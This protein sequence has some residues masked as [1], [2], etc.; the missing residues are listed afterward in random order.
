MTEAKIQ[1]TEENPGN[2]ENHDDNT[3]NEKDNSEEHSELSLEKSKKDSLG[4]SDDQEN[5]DD[6]GSLDDSQSH[7]SSIGG[8]TFLTSTN[9]ALVSN[10][11]PAPKQEP[12]QSFPFSLKDENTKK[13]LINLGYKEKDLYYPTDLEL[14]LYT[15]DPEIKET[16]KKKL[17]GIV[18]QRIKA[19]SEERLR[20][21]QTPRN[22]PRTNSGGDDDYF[23]KKNKEMEDN[24]RKEIERILIDFFKEK[25]KREQELKKSEN[26]EKQKAKV[27]EETRQRLEKKIK[28][29]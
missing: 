23:Q 10:Q 8:Q 21:V 2:E 20:L 14:N 26:S 28:R 18:D 13:A 11:T 29:G 22:H 17:H 25:I 9:N 15:H 24:Q 4:N 7:N 16:I 12:K 19:V 6:P 3:E 1:T 27:E 5:D